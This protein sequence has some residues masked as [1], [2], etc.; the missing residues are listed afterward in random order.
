MKTRT[1]IS[2]VTLL[3][4]LSGCVSVTPPVGYASY[5]QDRRYD[6][7]AVS[8]D[9]SVFTVRKID[10][11]D[12]ENGTLGFWTDATR[13]QLEQSRGYLFQEAGDFKSG[14]GPGRW[15]LFEHTYK[16][17]A[18]LYIVGVVVDGDKIWVMESTGEK[19]TFQADLPKVKKAFESLD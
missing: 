11:D 2:A 9:A 5:K 15:M 14:Q 8:T 18:Y 3:G 19:E 4:L 6:Q 1:I 16:G 10:N 7:K 12:E 17:N 13:K